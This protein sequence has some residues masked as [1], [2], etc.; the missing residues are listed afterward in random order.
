LGIPRSEEC[1]E[2]W[3]TVAVPLVALIAGLMGLTSIG[4]RQHRAGARWPFMC[5]WPLIAIY[6]LGCGLAGC[7]AVV[8]RLAR[9]DRCGALRIR[10]GLAILSLPAERRLF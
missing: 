1:R 10:L 4:L 2:S 5:I 3:L 8:A 7:G 6:G 9:M